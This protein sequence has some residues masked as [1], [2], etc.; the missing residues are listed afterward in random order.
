MTVGKR[1]L[2]LCGAVLGLVVLWPVGLLIA[3]AIVL[4]DWGPVFF[5]QERVLSLI[6]ITDPTTPTR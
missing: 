4:D 5:R 6:N 3:L 2:D 1:A